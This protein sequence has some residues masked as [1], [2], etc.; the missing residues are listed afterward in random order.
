[1]CGEPG[2][3][4]PPPAG[5]LREAHRK[6][7]FDEVLGITLNL[8]T[9][10]DE[11]REAV[12]VRADV[13][14]RAQADGVVFLKAVDESRMHRK[15]DFLRGRIIDRGHELEVERERATVFDRD[16]DGKNRR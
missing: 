4:R 9:A 8:P 10:L 5:L 3:S 12:G 14:G 11:R 16:A 13:E 15:R 7:S 1:M 6:I 2:G